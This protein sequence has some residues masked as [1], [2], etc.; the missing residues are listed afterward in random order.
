[1]DTLKE[2]GELLGAVVGGPLPPWVYWGIA[3]V[4][5]LRYALRLVGEIGEL[6]TK[7]IQPLFYNADQRRL[8][9][10]RQ[11]FAQH[12]RNTVAGVSEYEEWQDWR[13]AELEAEVEA[14]SY[15]RTPVLLRVLSPSRRVQRERS[16]SE[17]LRKTEDRLVLL[18]GPPGA[19][20][21]VALRHLAMLLADR[22]SRR[23]TCRSVIPVYVNLRDL[24]RGDTEG[25]DGSLVRRLVLSTLTA[26]HDRL[27]DRFIEEH[28]DQGLKDGTWLFLF[29]SFDEIPEV[30]TAPE[31]SDVVNRY[32]DA[33][34][35][36]LHGMNKC[37]AVVASREFRGPRQFGWPR[38]RI[39]PLSPER[40]LALV[41]RAR[42]EPQAEQRIV[43]NLLTATP[44]LRQLLANPMFLSTVCEH[45][46]GGNAFPQ[47]GH[48]VFEQFLT[49]R[50]ERDTLRVR[51]R[52][53]LDVADVEHAAKALAFCMTAE[54]GLGLNPSLDRIRGALRE[55]CFEVAVLDRVLNSLTYMRIGRLSSPDGGTSDDVRFSF[56]HRRFQEYFATRFVLAHPAMVAP[57][58]LLTEGKWRETAVVAL[59]VM[60]VEGLAPLIAQAEAIASFC[61]ATAGLQDDEMDQALVAIQR[62]DHYPVQ[63]DTDC[64]FEWPPGALHLLGIL[65]QALGARALPLPD[66][67]RADVARLVLAA[68]ATGVLHDRKAALDVAGSAPQRVREAMIAAGAR[69][70]S[71]WLRGA[72][73]EQ[74]A[75][76]P[77]GM[78][79]LVRVIPVA[80]VSQLLE[81]QLARQ[82]TSMATYISR[83]PRPRQLLGTL[84]ILA[85]LPA[86]DA[87]LHVSLLAVWGLLY[88]TGPHWASS[89]QMSA[90]A[91]GGLATAASAGL[92]AACWHGSGALQ[93]LVRKAVASYGDIVVP[94]FRLRRA[95]GGAV[96]A[97]ALL[98]IRMALSGAVLGIQQHTGAH[99]QD[100]P[101][102]G[103]T[104][105]YQYV[106]AWAPAVA[107]GVSS[108]L[109][110]NAA[111][112]PVL[113]IILLPVAFGRAAVAAI[114]E[115]ARAIPRVR[116]TWR[117][118]WR[119]VAGRLNTLVAGIALVG[120]VYGAL[121]LIWAVARD[122]ALCVG[123][124]IV[125][126]GASWWLGRWAQYLYLFVRDW[127]RWRAASRE[128]PIS[129]ECTTLMA[130]L[131][132]FELPVFAASLLRQVRVQ[133]QLRIDQDCLGLLTH[134][135]HAVHSRGRSRESHAP[136]RALR[137]A[138]GLQA[139]G[140]SP[141]EVEDI[142]RWVVTRAGTSD[143]VEEELAML[144][145]QARARLSG[146]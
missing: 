115:T 23:R 34:L 67:L 45:V 76:Q 46:Q 51:E 131:S 133:G 119:R 1:M 114:A 72:A 25:I 26:P 68:F 146:G 145:D 42:L 27:V 14:E 5:L 69:S 20:K 103:M 78:Q 40:A 64:E 87:I 17:A 59:Q 100:R 112:V 63:G 94:L 31:G 116:R 140:L 132:R 9:E 142:V 22:A 4:V 70:E 28:F 111:W 134:L 16:L 7:H 29:D 128:T 8:A 11:L 50:I 84:R 123:G 82:R 98:C 83:L 120:A 49:R 127:L 105:A 130:T 2:L 35:S 55:Q 60:D 144:I 62:G 43:A 129:L 106:A 81:G 61:A 15:S 38:F 58:A 136:A 107:I 10:D 139:R 135:A 19:G 125:A 89:E 32:A 54:E 86:V 93:T 85:M 74:A 92:G 95:T 57:N 122:A 110:L 80:M 18:E 96:E 108:R 77:E 88:A 53:G 71:L 137:L 66:L 102:T 126:I 12:L 37:R 91:R 21:S 109:F 73:F 124:V 48:E 39:M 75:S 113:P 141:A 36:F 6:W 33:I 138:A 104:L 79:K 121:W 56:A 101:L 65:Q 118:L 52:Y 44:E 41:R 90:L 3:L 99:A 97:I 143:E 24:Q 117:C 30:L 47:Q 13:F